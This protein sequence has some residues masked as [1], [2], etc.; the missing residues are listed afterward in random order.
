MGVSI[1]IMEVL[2]VVDRSK[3][4]L[5]PKTSKIQ[6]PKTIVRTEEL[7]FLDSDGQPTSDYDEW[8]SEAYY[9]TKMILSESR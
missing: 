9:L 2:V 3:N 8:N 6:S 4:W 1:V 5:S 7:S